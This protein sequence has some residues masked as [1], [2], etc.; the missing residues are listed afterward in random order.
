MVRGSRVQPPQAGKMPS[1]T[2]GRPIC[3]FFESESS[4]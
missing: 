4:R 1:R 2:S 3:A